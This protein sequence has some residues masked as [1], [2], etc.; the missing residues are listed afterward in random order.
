MKILKA[1]NPY[2]HEY[3][4]IL[5]GNEYIEM[6]NM[7]EL[8]KKK[9]IYHTSPNQLD[10]KIRY[11]F[12]ALFQYECPF[13]KGNRYYWFSPVFICTDI[14]NEIDLMH[15]FMEDYNGGWKSNKLKQIEQFDKY[16]EYPD[17]VYTLENEYLYMGHGY[18]YGTLPSDG[19]RDTDIVMI[20]ISNGDIIVGKTW[21]WYNK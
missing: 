19:S 17:K 14:P 18:T 20:H 15:Q 3:G 7:E 8:R 1:K 5:Y 12:K 9:Y 6:I 4:D 2:K 21:V 16:G 10:S 11:K 13:I